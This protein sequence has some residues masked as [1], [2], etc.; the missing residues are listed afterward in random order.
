MESTKAVTEARIELTNAKGALHVLWGRASTDRL[1]LCNAIEER[2][3]A[4]SK[5]I[6]TAAKLQ[7]AKR[8]STVPFDHLKRHSSNVQAAEAAVQES[9]NSNL[10]SYMQIVMQQVKQSTEAYKLNTEGDISSLGMA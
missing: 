2:D 6:M 3:G 7:V 10:H 5:G 8:A 9:I 1:A 4:Q